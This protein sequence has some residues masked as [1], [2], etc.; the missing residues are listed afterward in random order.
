MV[1]KV[2]LNSSNSCIP[3]MSVFTGIKEAVSQLAKET[4]AIAKAK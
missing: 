4:K 2:Q 3:D 1:R